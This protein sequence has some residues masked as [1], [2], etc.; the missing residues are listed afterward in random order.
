MAKTSDFVDNT[1]VQFLK[2]KFT[3]LPT[4]KEARNWKSRLG[5]KPLTLDEF[6]SFAKNMNIQHALYMNKLR[7]RSLFVWYLSEC[8]KWLTFWSLREFNDS[9]Y[10]NFCM[11]NLLE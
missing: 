8:K 9:M 1:W 10:Q 5:G 6:E 7:Q 11:S 4:L 3:N 2:W